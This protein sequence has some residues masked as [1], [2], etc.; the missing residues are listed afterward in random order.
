MIAVLPPELTGVVPPPPPCAPSFVVDELEH[1]AN[2][3]V[4]ESTSALL[5]WI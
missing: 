2:V 4:A 5:H 1:A 3:R